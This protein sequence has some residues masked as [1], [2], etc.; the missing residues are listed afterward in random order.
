VRRAAL[1]SGMLLL[2]GSA[3][4]WAQTPREPQMP[5]Q[6]DQPEETQPGRERNEVVTE[7][8][9][10]PGLK[11]NAW[12]LDVQLGTLGLAKTFLKADRILVDYESDAGSALYGNM[13][14]QGQSSFSPQV[15]LGHTI[16]SFSLEEGVGFAIGDFK[17][18]VDRGSIVSPAPTNTNTLTD[19]EVK[20]GS[21]FMW[22]H[23]TSVSWYPIVRGRLLPYV[24]GGVGGQY[25]FLDSSNYVHGTTSSLAFSTGVGLR[26]VGDNVLSARLEV[27]NYWYSV[28]FTPSQ[29]FLK[30]VPN[31]DRGAPVGERLLNI[32]LTA[33]D[34]DG[35]AQQVTKYDKQSFSNL[36]MS[37]GFVAAF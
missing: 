12:Q 19:N 15:K 20:T 14:L 31:P 10:V 25:Y 26:L 22:F 4:A 23:E 11:R 37:V 13:S 3:G 18:Q 6:P 9:F 33:L 29:N 1:L 24:S 34:A 5:K 21:Y 27:R 8:L 16:K 2:L 30:D 35:T 28:D 36:W 17:Q 7:K 32:P